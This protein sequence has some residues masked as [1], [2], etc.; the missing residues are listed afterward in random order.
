MIILS[1]AQ[2]KVFVNTNRTY[3]KSGEKF[4]QVESLPDSTL[5]DDPD[6]VPAQLLDDDYSDDD[7]EDFMSEV[8]E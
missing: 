8:E 1:R 7:E 4:A 2:P 5:D 6:Y 3:T